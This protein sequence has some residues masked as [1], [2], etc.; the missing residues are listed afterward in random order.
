MEVTLNHSNWLLSKSG[1]LQMSTDLRFNIF[2]VSLE[3]PESVSPY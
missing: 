1:F 3:L 2:G